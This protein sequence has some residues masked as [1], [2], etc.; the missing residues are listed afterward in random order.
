MWHV[1]Y[2]NAYCLKI[3]VSKIFVI[4]RSDKKISAQK[5]ANNGMKKDVYTHV[6]VYAW[7]GMKG[8]RQV[9][10]I[11]SFVV[12]QFILSNIILIVTN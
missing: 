10:P 8:I 4:V 2:G 11:R 9:W 5:K 3:F 6:H 12:S 1:F 7:M